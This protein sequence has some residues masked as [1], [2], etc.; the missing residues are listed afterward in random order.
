M[1]S[2]QYDIVWKQRWSKEKLDTV[3]VKAPV[4]YE[5]RDIEDN[6]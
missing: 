4:E 2:L 6:A 3:K 5:N 1:N